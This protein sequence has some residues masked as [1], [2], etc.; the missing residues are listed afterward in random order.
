MIMIAPLLFEVKANMPANGSKT[1]DISPQRADINFKQLCAALRS[2]SSLI[3][4]AV[5]TS[6]VLELR[7]RL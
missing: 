4:D 7:L 3:P 2:S 6:A 5:T 1:K